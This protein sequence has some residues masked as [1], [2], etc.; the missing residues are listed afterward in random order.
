[1]TSGTTA[2]SALPALTLQALRVQLQAKAQRPE[3]PHAGLD[4][5]ELIGQALQQARCLWLNAPAGYGKSV[6][7]AD[8]ARQ[9]EQA[10]SIVLWLN[11]DSRDQSDALLMRH[12]LEL[13]ERHQPGLAGPALAHWH[14]TA[15]R[16]QVDTEQ[17]LLLWLEH[18]QHTPGPLLFCLDNVHELRDGSSLPLLVRL[19]ELLPAQT[20]VLLASRAQPAA[21]GRLRLLP[22]LRWLGLTD[23]RFSDDDTQR[24]L[25]QHGVSDAAVRVPQLSQYLQG[26][27][28]GLAIWLACYRAA[29]QPAEAGP[30]LALTEL[31]D[32][33]SGEVLQQ[34]APG[35]ADFLCLVAVLGSFSEPLLQHVYTD[36]GYHALFLQARQQNL[37]ISPIAGQDGW[38]QMHPVMA[39]LLSQQLPAQRRNTLHRLAF[40]W[41]S[42]QPRLPVAALRHALAAGMGEEV[43]NWVADESEHILANLDIAGLLEWFD[44]LGD[45]VLS[46][47][48]RLMA[49]A[50]WAFLLTLQ[51]DRAARI[52]P[53]LL[54]RHS[55]QTFEA[56][57]LQGYL[58]RLDGQ[59]RRSADLCQRALSSAPPERFTLRMLMTSTL[60]HL[61][62][63][64][65]DTDGARNW[66]RQAQD[67]ARQYQ[68]PAMEALC[69]FDYAR[70]ELNRGHIDHCG[71]IIE[72]GLALLQGHLADDQRLPRGRLLLYRAV[73]LWLTGGD[74]RL[75]HD[76]LQQG[77]RAGTELRDV[78]VCYGYAV[79]AMRLA[80][81]GDCAAALDELDKAERLMQRWQAEVQS[82]RWLVLVRAN[83]WLTQGK[84][85]RAQQVLDDLLQGQSA[86]QLPRPELF[87]L[88]PGLAQM[89][90]ARLLLLAGRYD[91]CLTLTAKAM[92]HRGSALTQMLLGLLRAAALRALNQPEG[93]QILALA[94]RTLQREGV[95]ESLL[96]WFPGL[97]GPVPEPGER[98]EVV[99]NA[100]LSERELDV[101]RKIAQGLSNQ[102]IADQLFISLHTVKTH[103]R[104][105]NVKLGAK[106]RTQALHRAQELKL[107]G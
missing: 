83:V 48:P 47:S 45:E 20:R 53:R 42:A 89:T 79:Q 16:G 5:A 107:I 67:L 78:S 14:D 46:Q 87:P 49:I 15:S 82:Y 104:K 65:Q 69:L 26:W 70:I 96:D 64:E 105:I 19:L 58:A 32:Y 18:L 13:A 24:L 93:Q 54:T 60:A 81:Q 29:G 92:R 22:G 100:S 21:L 23:L 12:L 74:D 4:R 75:L 41:L 2:S 36:D 95:A 10:G 38:F 52:L 86:A 27:P 85:Q 6:L 44:L 51:R 9:Q 11:L 59:L 3:A 106:S 55:L 77:I 103:A 66:N 1:M 68:A 71:T 35:L 90:Q 39:G 37:F 56:D 84:L 28:A 62:L 97:R 40:A 91:D 34:L 25:Q 33:L 94:L 57:A 8:Y 80:A 17:V 101:L 30:E 63:A 31:S 43:Q 76:T 72:R 99:L 50:C 88:Q 98:E 61:R 7:M 73:L 102:E